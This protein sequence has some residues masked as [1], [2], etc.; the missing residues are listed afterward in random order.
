MPEGVPSRMT[1][2]GNTIPIE[3]PNAIIQLARSTKT[4]RVMRCIGVP[5][6]PSSLKGHD[7]RRCNRPRGKFGV[8]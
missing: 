8:V 6:F 1:K 3:T 2:N 4:L 5:P 7:R